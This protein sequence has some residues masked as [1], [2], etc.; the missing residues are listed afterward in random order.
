MIHTSYASYFLFTL[1]FW[2]VLNEHT[3][4][5]VLLRPKREF[6]TELHH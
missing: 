4:Y 3:V 6:K 1:T 2:E 5:V